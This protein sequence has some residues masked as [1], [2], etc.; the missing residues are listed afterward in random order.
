MKI[1]VSLFRGL[2]IDSLMIDIHTH[3][4]DSSHEAIC[5]LT[6][7]P[8]FSPDP[9][10]WYSVGIHPWKIEEF[11]SGKIATKEAL[12]LFSVHPRVLAIGEAGL[13]TLYPF[14][15]LPPSERKGLYAHSIELFEWQALLAEKV[16]KPLI[17]HCVR[18][19]DDLLR[20]KRTIRPKGLWIIHGFR[21]KPKQAEQFLNHGFAL[22]FG[23]YFNPEA[24]RIV[25]AELLFAETDESM[26][27]FPEILSRL[28]RA[29]AQ[30]LDSFSSSL[31][32]NV[33]R[34][35]RL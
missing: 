29:R 8:G 26:L 3:H 2:F 21:G 23:E 1:N 28:A 35:F 12:E 24:A 4:I 31:E 9:G 19:M 15:L 16:G 7:G 34:N 27:P 32:Q 6:P 33:R 18:A 25:P 30:D 10:K 22:S 11:L 5:S 13:D 20:L 14:S 17:I